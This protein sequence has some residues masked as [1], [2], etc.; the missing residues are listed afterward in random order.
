MKDSVRNLDMNA[1]KKVAGRS[2]F[3]PCAWKD[4][5]EPLDAFGDL[6]EEFHFVD[7]RYQFSRPVPMESTRWVLQPEFSSLTGPAV[8]KL[9]IVVSG[10]RRYREIEPAWWRERYV[11]RTTGRAVRVTRRRGFG[12]IALDELPDNSLGV[13]CHRGDSLGEGGSGTWYLANHNMSYSPLSRLFDTIK[14]KLAYPALIVSDG[15][16]TRIRQITDCCIERSY[17]KQALSLVTEF[18]HFGLHWQRVGELN[19]DRHRRTY[20]WLVE[21]NDQ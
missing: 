11:D 18:D 10:E 8:D 6:I 1:I 7:L 19:A 9:R 2:F 5:I 12:Q 21:R 17:R 4:W 16:N 15:S 14:R 13:F 20:V 3:Y